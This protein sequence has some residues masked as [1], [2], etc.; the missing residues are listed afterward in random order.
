MNNKGS[1]MVLLVIVIALLI[2]L[3]TSVLSVAVG[4]YE[5]KK[6]N[7]EAKQCFYMSEKG[8][9][10]AYVKSCALI[11]E[12]IGEA[13]QLAENYLII[14]PLDLIEA[15]SIF[16]ANYRIYIGANIED[17]IE[18]SANPSIRVWNNRPIMFDDSNVLRLVLKSKYVNEN[19][20][21]RTTGV[22][23]VISV[24]DYADVADGAYDA[25]DYIDFQN[26]NS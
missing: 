21:D 4:Q 20:V 14:N 7:I 6:V 24:P 16:I 15:N 17:R 8:L 13:I 2:V 23:L 26:W 22:D 9:N 25:R 19:K 10:E 1:T 12:S 18:S 3:G 11:D 5:I